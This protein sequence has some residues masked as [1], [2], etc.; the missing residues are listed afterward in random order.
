MPLTKIK[1]QEVLISPHVT[2]KA[3]GLARENQYVFKVHSAAGKIEI[4]KAVKQLFKVTP[5]KVN[6]SNIQGKKRRVG[7]I[8]GR[9]PGFKKAIITLKAGET[10]ESF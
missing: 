4:K 2:E 5:I 6:V 7:R 3:T 1:K 10:I 8:Q 9:R